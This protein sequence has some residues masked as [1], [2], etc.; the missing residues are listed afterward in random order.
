MTQRFLITNEGIDRSIPQG[1][2]PVP[3]AR[4]RGSAKAEPFQNRFMR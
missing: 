2:K 1:L 3:L 4:L